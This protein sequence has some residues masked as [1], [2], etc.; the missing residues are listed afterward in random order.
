[1]SLYIEVDG[2]AAVL[3]ADGWHTI[4][5]KSFDLDAYEFQHSNTLLGGADVCST[6]AIWTEADGAVVC[7]PLTAVLAIRSKV[8]PTHGNAPRSA[9][10]ITGRGKA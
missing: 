8:P 5:D 7:C 4:K 2:I 9:R 10:N 1:M 3:L 6:G